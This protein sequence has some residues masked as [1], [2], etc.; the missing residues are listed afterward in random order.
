MNIIFTE[1]NTSPWYVV[2][3][4]V[5]VLVCFFLLF[6]ITGWILW[7]I[8]LKIEK[9]VYSSFSLVIPL[10]D[11]RREILLSSIKHIK[12]KKYNCN[13]DLLKEIQ[14]K[15]TPTFDNPKDAITIKDGMD[16]GAMYITKVLKT[17]GKSLIDDDFIKQIYEANEN[18]FQAYNNFSKVAA[19]YNAIFLMPS[20]KLVNKMHK[21]GNRRTRISYM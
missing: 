7:G 15:I 18:S 14:D 8:L 19:R 4:V 21:K 10:E 5:I 20:T 1:N 11:K 17:Y 12:E 2:L 16:F 9:K 13:K 6:L 3:I